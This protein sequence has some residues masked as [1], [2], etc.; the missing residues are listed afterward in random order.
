LKGPAYEA[1]V[2]LQGINWWSSFGFLAQLFNLKPLPVCTTS[3]EIIGMFWS[4]KSLSVK[5]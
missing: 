1:G 4:V 3:L 2:R 5:Q